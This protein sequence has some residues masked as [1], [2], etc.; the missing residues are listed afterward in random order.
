[1]ASES[2]LHLQYGRRH[3]SK[4]A[5]SRWSGR[6]ANGTPLN[7]EPSGVSKEEVA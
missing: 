4:A 7:A 5:H 3:R 6:V 2:R 1:M